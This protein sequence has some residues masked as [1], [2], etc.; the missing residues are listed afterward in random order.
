VVGQ[1]RSEEVIVVAGAEGNGGDAGGGDDLVE[2]G[3]ELRGQAGHRVVALDDDHRLGA[4]RREVPVLL[5]PL[6]PPIQLGGRED[7][8]Q[9]QRRVRH[10]RDVTVHP[11]RLQQA[12]RAVVTHRHHRP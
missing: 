10:D 9:E 6:S 11:G 5:K 3:G 12:P 1:G 8:G 2:G 7:A 4:L